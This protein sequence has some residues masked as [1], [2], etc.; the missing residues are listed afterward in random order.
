[1][2]AEVVD[3]S[4]KLD[5]TDFG[6]KTTFELSGDAVTGLGLTAGTYSGSDVAGTIG[7]LAATGAGRL[8]TGAE[9]G[10]TEGLTIRYAGTGTGPA[11]ELSYVLGVSG[12]ID[13]VLEQ[14]T[15]A[16]NGVIAGQVNSIDASIA[17]LNRRASDVESRLE[18]RRAAL[19][20]QFVRMEQAMSLMNSQSA[21]L[22]N[23]IMAMSG[24]KE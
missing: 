18:L 16:G 19:T 5:S 12:M 9:G 21:W 10:D 24:R 4:L 14:M 22:S 15:R 23:Q 3:G 1:M 7:G 17:T 11:G 6:S 2:T 8:L 20:E 13:R